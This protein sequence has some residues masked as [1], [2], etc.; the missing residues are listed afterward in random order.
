MRPGSVSGV[1]ELSGGGQVKV[2]ARVCV[3]QDS[4]HGSAVVQVESKSKAVLEALEALKVALRDE[5]RQ[6]M[7]DILEG[8]KAWDQS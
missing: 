5:A 3:A 4:I 7:A 1:R 8:Q 2:Q 6:M